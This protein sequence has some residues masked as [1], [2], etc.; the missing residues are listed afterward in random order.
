VGVLTD[1]KG[2]L[3]DGNG[4]ARG[5]I[6]VHPHEAVRGQT[7]DISQQYATFGNNRVTFIDLA[8]HEK[9]LKTT[10]RGISTYKPDF[11]L[12]CV[13]KNFG[14]AEVKDG[15]GDPSEEHVKL[16]SWMKIPFIVLITKI[17]Q[18]PVD[19]QQRTI[20]EFKEF[21]KTELKRKVYEIKKES[22]LDLALDTKLVPLL[23]ISNKTGE[24]LDMLRQVLGRIEAQQRRVP[25]WFTVDHV[26]TVP[27]TGVVV[28]GF[29]GLELKKNQTLQLGP[30]D[31]KDTPWVE[32][33]IRNIRDDFDFDVDSVQPGQR[34]CLWLKWKA[35]DAHKIRTGHVL[36]EDLKTVKITRRFE[37]TVII[38]HHHTTI[39][40]GYVCFVNCGAL[41]EPVKFTAVKGA[42]TL[43]SGMKAKV[44]I[45]FEQHGNI[46]NTG[47]VFFFRE[48]NTRGI[49][50]VIQLYD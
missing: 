15:Y 41:K 34:C 46:V 43:R 16:L 35:I 38:W 48:G 25:P 27:H 17:D 32:T 3:D 24:G 14:T 36:V 13:A 10:I 12:V 4:M 29:T 21:A 31:E 18:T 23:K 40:A 19:V 26:Y 49:G 45:E 30:Y 11:A 20:R 39:K 9:Y 6:L 7:S 47:D 2:V 42:L 8:G 50:K 1:A 37:A 28:S 5:R 33:K 22:D 44:D